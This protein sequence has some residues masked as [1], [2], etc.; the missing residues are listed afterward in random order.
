MELAR[1][2]D[3]IYRAPRRDAPPRAGLGLGLYIVA[4]IVS[5]HGGRLW[6]ESVLGRGSTFIVE[7]PLT[8]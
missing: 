1:I 3:R 8:G 6:A 4:E 2:F 7:L 5:R